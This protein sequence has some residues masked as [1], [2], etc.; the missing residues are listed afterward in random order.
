MYLMIKLVSALLMADL[1]GSILMGLWYLAARV[2][3]KRGYTMLLFYALRV[4]VLFFL[5]PAGFLVLSFFNDSEGIWGG[6]LFHGTPAIFI[7]FLTLLLIWLAGAVHAGAPYFREWRRTQYQFS[8]AVPADKEQRDAFAAVCREMRKRP[9]RV[10]VYLKYGMYC[11]ITLGILRP[12]IILPDAELEETELRVTLM[13]EMIHYSRGDM[14][15][16]TAA[17]LILLFH[18]YNPLAHRLESLVRRW[19]EYACDYQVCSYMGG[20]TQ[21][22]GVLFKVALKGQGMYSSF[23]SSIGDGKSEMGRRIDMMRLMDRKRSAVFGVLA[24]LTMTLSAATSVLAATGAAAEGYKALYQATE[25]EHMEQDNLQGDTDSPVYLDNS[26]VDPLDYV[27]TGTEFI[28][29]LPLDG[30]TVE[31]DGASLLRT[32]SGTFYWSINPEVMKTTSYFWVSAN[33]TIAVSGTISPSGKVLRVGVIYP[34]GVRH[35]IYAT[36]RFSYQFD[37][38]YMGHYC[39]YAINDNSDVV[40]LDGVYAVY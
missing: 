7:A 38:P 4:V 36:G 8:N 35:C 20:I 29:T 12:R 37:A 31:E 9:G 2:L 1:W 5:L 33:S 18:W 39:V 34:D 23:S 15:L 32:T 24:A 14:Y 26:Q 22:I 17:V 28:D 27:D 25:Q 3:E 11:G 16:K 21:Y 40:S 6:V 13:H 30:Y 10:K 19:C